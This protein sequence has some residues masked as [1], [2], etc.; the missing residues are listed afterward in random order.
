MKLAIDLI[1]LLVGNDSFHTFVGLL[2]YQET[3]LIRLFGLNFS[4]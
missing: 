1:C 4:S 3:A 2:C